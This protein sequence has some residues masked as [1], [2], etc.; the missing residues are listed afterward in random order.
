MSDDRKVD[1]RLFQAAVK[2]DGEDGWGGY[3][4]EGPGSVILLL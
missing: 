1:P 3:S 2:S 4:R